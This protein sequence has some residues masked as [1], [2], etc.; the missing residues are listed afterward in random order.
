MQIQTTATIR[1]RWQITIPDEIRKIVDWAKPRSVVSVRV[2]AKNELVI[3]PLESGQER[4]VNWD[5]VWKAIHEAR[6]I[7]SKG[8]KMSLSR[9]IVRDR[10]RHRT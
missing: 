3:N 5:E 1:D 8:K 4:E 2:T 7:S 10:E 9:F 6:I